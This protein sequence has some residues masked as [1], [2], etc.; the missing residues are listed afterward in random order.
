MRAWWGIY[1]NWR[2]KNIITHVC[3]SQEAGMLDNIDNLAGG[4]VNTGHCNSDKNGDE[5]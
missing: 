1:D 5:D 4:A 2:L 3:V